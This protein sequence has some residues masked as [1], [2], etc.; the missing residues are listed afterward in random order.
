[1]NAR[2]GEILAFRIAEQEQWSSAQAVRDGKQPPRDPD[3]DGLVELGEG[4]RR[5][6]PVA[7]RDRLGL[8][9]ERVE[10]RLVDGW[11]ETVSV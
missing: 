8:R 6:A 4:L 10:K 3:R 7:S 1:M 2:G 9:R 5:Y 11:W